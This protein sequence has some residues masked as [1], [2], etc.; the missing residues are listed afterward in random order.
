MPPAPSS[1]ARAT[2]RIYGAR[3]LR[4]AIQRLIENPLAKR[5]LAGEFPTGQHGPRRPDRATSSAS[6]PSRAMSDRSPRRS[7]RT[8]TEPG[9][10]LAPR[11][12][13]S[14]L[15]GEQTHMTGDRGDRLRAAMP[16]D[17]PAPEEA[18][19]VPEAEDDAA[20]AG[21]ESKATD[22]EQ[23]HHDHPDD[24]RDDQDHQRATRMTPCRARPRRRT[25]HSC[26]S[27]MGRAIELLAAI[28]R[29]SGQLRHPRRW[30]SSTSSSSMPPD[31]PGSR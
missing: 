7:R 29:H 9:R 22:D 2:T 10:L 12:P 1:R 27:P 5:I 11:P 4:R 14:R 13:A 19:T 24:H 26:W 16:I 6:K 30:A 21:A 18:T 20:L 3:P 17:E 25:D 31:W 23:A 15:R 8:R 28:A